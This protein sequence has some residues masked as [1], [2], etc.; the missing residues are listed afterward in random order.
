MSAS[1]RSFAGCG[2]LPMELDPEQGMAT[3]KLDFSLH[4][5]LDLYLYFEPNA[6]KHAATDS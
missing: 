4:L 3:R 6:S 2:K 5:T 1:K